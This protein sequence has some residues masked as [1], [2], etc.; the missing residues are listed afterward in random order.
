MIEIP[1]KISTLDQLG[2]TVFP[3]LLDIA[4]KNANWT[5]QGADPRNFAE[6][7]LLM[8]KAGV[9]GIMAS[10]GSGNGH[11]FF[12]TIGTNMAEARKAG[13]TEPKLNEIGY[14]IMVA[15]AKHG[16]QDRTFWNYYGDPAQSVWDST[17]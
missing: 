7:L 3:I 17:Y 9:A 10:G 12:R 5:S 13:R 8:P 2:N 16:A 11:G 6:S 4:C 14:V 15:K 1:L